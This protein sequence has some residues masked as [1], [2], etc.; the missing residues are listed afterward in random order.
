MVN[1]AFR[2]SQSV[3]ALF[4]CWSYM[5][6]PTQLSTTVAHNCIS[7]FG[8]ITMVCIH[9]NTIATRKAHEDHRFT[10]VNIAWIRSNMKCVLPWLMLHPS[11]K[12]NDNNVSRFSII[13]L[14][15]QQTEHKTNSMEK[16][17]IKPKDI[18]LPSRFEQEVNKFN[19]EIRT[20]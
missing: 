19:H 2:L 17:F 4:G 5:T 20:S 1:R 7:L 15:G 13:L 12:F 18:S 14:T 8:E 3:F 10:A 6:Q 16:L 11:G 9:V